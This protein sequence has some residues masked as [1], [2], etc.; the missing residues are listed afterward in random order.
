MLYRSFGKDNLSISQ[1]GFGCMRLPI[2]DGD[3]G[4]IDVEEAAHMVQKAID[5]GVNYI[6]TAWPYH[7]GQSEIFVGDFLEKTNQR[8]KVYLAT[9]LPLFHLDETTDFYATL[10][11]QLE[12]LKTSYFDF[13]L[14]HNIDDK[15]WDKIIDM[16]IFDFNKYA[17]E[18]GKVKHLGFSFHDDVETFKRV[19]DSYD[20]DFCQIQLNYMDENF[21]AG[22]EG[23]RYANEKGLPVIIMEPIKGGKLAFNLKGELKEIW[24]KHNV[25][26][27]PPQLALKYLWN[28]PEVSLVLSGMSTMEHVEDNLK[29]AESFGIDSL[30]ENEKNL[31]K[32]LEGFLV[33]KTEID[34][35]SCKYCSDCPQNIP[36]WDVFTLYNNSKIY[37][38][39]KGSIGSYSRMDPTRRADSCI[40]CG[41]CESVCPQ[42]LTIIDYL[43]TCHKTFTE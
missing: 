10:D 37:D 8:D 24:D 30:A 2:L 17:K 34:C 38:D 40:E 33:S 16:G 22:L 5:S 3:V 11:K 23:L 12:K 35:T 31:I 9:K 28:M 26:L 13:Y 42:N 41:L 39:L 20:F 1:L 43:K 27:T 14:L 25:N 32:E 7:N 21:Q 19:I 15:K 29:S 6:D 36:I 4:K 18:S